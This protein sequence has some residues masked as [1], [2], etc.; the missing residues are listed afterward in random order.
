MAYIPIKGFLPDVDPSLEGVLPMVVDA[1][2][3]VRGYEAMPGAENEGVNTA[4]ASV[5]GADSI[6][7]LDGTTRTFM[8]T[9]TE[10]FENSS[11]TWADRSSTTAGYTTTTRWRFGVFGND[12]IA[13]SKENTIQFSASGAFADLTGAPKAS[14]VEIVDRQA[15]ALNVDDGGTDDVDRWRTSAQ[16]DIHDWA[17]SVATLAATGRLVDTPGA[18]T[19]GRRVGKDI[20][21]YKDTSL[22]LGRFVGPPIVLDFD[23]ISDDI[24]AP[25]QEAVVSVENFGHL[26]P[27]R[28]DF[29]LFNGAQMQHVGQGRI[30]G[31]FFNRRLDLAN[32]SK[33]I[34]VE[35]PNKS[36]VIWWYPSVD[37]GGALDEWVSFNYHTGKWGHGKLEV[38]FPFRAIFDSSPTYATLGDLYTTYADLPEIPYNSSFWSNV[39]TRTSY[40]DSSGVLKSLSGTGRDMEITLSDLGADDRYSFQSRVR[41]RFSAYPISGKLVN[42]YRD[43]LGDE[44]V[45]SSGTAVLS[46]GKFDMERESRWHRN[47]MVFSSITGSAVE[48]LGFDV[49]LQEAGVE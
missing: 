40:F 5:V 26:F 47:R 28:E 11:G 45:S 12:S 7:Q 4:T 31:W 39:N 48:V 34:G 43:N 1:L 14:I 36:R 22:Y 3:S 35:N 49:T 21:V 23:L 38:T 44:P 30:A 8:G 17:T 29:Y 2:P 9:A 25:S 24:G 32:R 46:D 13:A 37:G 18:I 6:T 15:V 42:S 41:P 33:I 19:A 27:G 16:D 10:I 20:A